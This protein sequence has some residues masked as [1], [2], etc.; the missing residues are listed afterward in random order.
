ME[1][2]DTEGEKTPEVKEQ[3][4][5]VGYTRGAIQ[6]HESTN[7]A[8]VV[9]RL[10]GIPDDVPEENDRQ[11]GGVQASYQQE[12]RGRLERIPR[13]RKPQEQPW[14]SHMEGRDQDW[15]SNAGQGHDHEDEN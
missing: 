13:H 12:H 14:G 1:R 11:P 15:R 8:E 4:K 3:L 6:G 5:E 2:V 9:Q 10:W 7:A